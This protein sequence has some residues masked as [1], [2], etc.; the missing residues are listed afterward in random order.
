GGGAAGTVSIDLR[1]DGPH[2][3]AAGTTGAGKSEL[4]QSLVASLAASHP[5]NRLT[6]VLVDYKGGGAFKDCVALPH[7][8]GFFTDLD[9]HLAQRA[10]V[11]LNAE[12][13]RREEALRA[14][15]AK[16]LAELEER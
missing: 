16:D 13:R 11:S 1:R 6:F 9:A 4:L 10:L 12:L 7:T 2:G 8:G 3:L 14:H 15:G 5:A